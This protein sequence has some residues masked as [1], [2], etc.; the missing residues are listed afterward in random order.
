MYKHCLSANSQNYST[1]AKLSQDEIQIDSAAHIQFNSDRQTDID[2][3]LQQR[4]DFLNC[5]TIQA[6][7][8]QAI[9]IAQYDGWLA[10]HILQLPHCTKVRAL[11]NIIQLLQCAPRTVN[12]TAKTTSCGPQP[13][14]N[15]SYTI[16]KTG[17]ELVKFQKCYWSSNWINF[18]GNPFTYQS[19]DWKPLHYKS[20]GN[21]QEIHHAFKYAEDDSIAFSTHINPA[22]DM[23]S[24]DHF[25]VVADLAAPIS[26]HSI[27][28]TKQ[29]GSQQVF[30]SNY[31]TFDHVQKLQILTSFWYTWVGK[32]CIA[33][34]TFAAVF[35]SYF[36]ATSENPFVF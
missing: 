35:F 21:Q 27:D 2:N 4:I 14:F 28:E 24:L 10:A 20:L 30:F 7:Q 6:K 5:K 32:F 34:I 33:L 16:S 9:A 12:F 31:M 11:G 19:G 17:W 18:N 15:N 22:Y 29:S 8:Q 26:Q 23:V 25:N 13:V 1:P 36:Y 3:L